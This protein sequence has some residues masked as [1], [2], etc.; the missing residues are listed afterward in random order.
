MRKTRSETIV[1]FVTFHREGDRVVATATSR[2]LRRF[3][4]RGHAGNVP[5]AYLT[6]YLA[7]RRAKAAGV[8]AAVL[9][10]GLHPP[11]RGN[12]V[13]AALRGIQEAGVEV[14]S[15]EAVLPE[16]ARLRGEHLPKSPAPGVEDLKAKLEAG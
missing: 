6:G 5:A 4:W 9:D 16:E 12:R 10:I 1:Q 15:G 3:D 13:F 11:T 14:P 7:G 2:E 8:E